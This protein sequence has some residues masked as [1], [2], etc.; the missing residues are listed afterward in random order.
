M[1]EINGSGMNVTRA[2]QSRAILMINFEVCQKKIYDT[3][4]ANGLDR[5]GFPT[6]GT[7]LTLSTS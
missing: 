7:G 5:W 3:R 1:N 6:S 2:E 4:F